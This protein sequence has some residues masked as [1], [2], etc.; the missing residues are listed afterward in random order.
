M[1]NYRLSNM[2]KLTILLII[3]GQS[4]RPHFK[5]VFHYSFGALDQRLALEIDAWETLTVVEGV[6]GCVGG[7]GMEEHQCAPARWELIK[8]AAGRFVGLGAVCLDAMKSAAMVNAD[9]LRKAT[10]NKAWQGNWALRCVDMLAY[11]KKQLD[12]GGIT[13]SLTKLFVAHCETTK[14]RSEGVMCADVYLNLE[15]DVEDTLP[16]NSCYCHVP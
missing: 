3:D 14:P 12:A 15:W 4:W 5:S 2:H 6:L 7:A 10:N 1:S 16:C 9:A 13:T 11:L 8:R